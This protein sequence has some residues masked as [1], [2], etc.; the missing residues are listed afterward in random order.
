[1]IACAFSPLHSAAHAT[2]KQPF[3]TAFKQLSSTS[4][5]QAVA[6]VPTSRCCCAGDSVANAAIASTTATPTTAPIAPAMIHVVASSAAIAGAGA[7][8]R[9]CVDVATGGGGA[10]R[11]SSS[12]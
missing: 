7:G 4:P 1:M 11:A 5:A 10:D 3:T 2:L 8:A 12:P 9:A 6:Q